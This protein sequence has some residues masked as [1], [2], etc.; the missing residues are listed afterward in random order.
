[1]LQKYQ[2]L[3]QVLHASER[4]RWI[5]QKFALNLSSSLKLE[6]PNNFDEETTFSYDDNNES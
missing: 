2:N 1:M 4:F 5:W 6:A 3:N